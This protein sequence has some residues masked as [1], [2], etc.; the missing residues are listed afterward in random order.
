MATVR[1]RERSELVLEPA[2]TRPAAAHGPLMSGHDLHIELQFWGHEGDVVRAA[3]WREASPLRCAVLTQGPAVPECMLD[4]SR[5]RTTFSER[6]G[7]VAR[8]APRP[9]RG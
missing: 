8:L 2:V 4:W 3:T 5:R 6:L 1:N 7:Q 9:H